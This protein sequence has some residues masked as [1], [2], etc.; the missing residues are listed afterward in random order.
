MAGE[1]PLG[2]GLQSGRT[3]RTEDIMGHAEYRFLF[4]SF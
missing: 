3:T 1:Q 4:S 2:E